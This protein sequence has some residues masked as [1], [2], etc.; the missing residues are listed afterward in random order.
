MT[1]RAWTQTD[2]RALRAAVAAHPPVTRLS[3]LWA[4]VGL[5]L[6]RS[7]AAVQERCRKLGIR[8]QRVRQVTTYCPQ[9]PCA[10]CA[11]VRANKPLDPA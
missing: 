7:A 6:D 3:I 8:P 9:C 2:I 10:D 5:K 4:N 11:R 1:A